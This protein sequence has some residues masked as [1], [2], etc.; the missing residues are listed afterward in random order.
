MRGS[1]RNRP[2]FRDLSCLRL[3]DGDARWTLL[4]DKLHLF[5][6][7]SVNTYCVHTATQRVAFCALRIQN[8][9][10]SSTA[11]V[12]SATQSWPH[13]W[14]CA[15]T[16]QNNGKPPPGRRLDSFDRVDQFIQVVGEEPRRDD[17]I[18]ALSRSKLASE[19]VLGDR[20]G[21]KHG[22]STN[23]SHQGFGWDPFRPHWQ[24]KTTSQPWN[25]P[26]KTTAKES[27]SQG[28][29]MTK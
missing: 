3:T 8:R 22:H 23:Q 5:Y 9:V 24:R 13:L 4:V 1:S 29:I 15:L 12:Q 27:P 7:N 21:L 11:I 25:N 20:D 17:D 16:I 2:P 6:T 10:R 18:R 26:H 14:F 28:K 19:I